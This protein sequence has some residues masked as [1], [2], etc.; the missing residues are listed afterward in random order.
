MQFKGLLIR[1]CLLHIRTCLYIAYEDRHSL[2]SL[3]FFKA[4][5]FWRPRSF[6]CL[7]LEIYSTQNLLAICYV[8]F[9]TFVL[10]FIKKMG[11]RKK[12]YLSE[13]KN[14]RR[15]KQCYHNDI[16]RL[17][18]DN[19]FSEVVIIREIVWKNMLKRKF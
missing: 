11:K 5:Y 10:Q 4:I 8:V 17:T 14:I 19:F 2:W 3:L 7:T 15:T 1:A 6:E 13:E 12:R 9:Y 16:C 18:R